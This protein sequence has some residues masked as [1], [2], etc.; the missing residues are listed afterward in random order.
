LPTR[1]SLGIDTD[2]AV[3]F[4]RV[5][6]GAPADETDELYVAGTCKIYATTDI[7]SEII[8]G[9]Y[10][11]TRLEDT[12][13]ALQTYISASGVRETQRSLAFQFQEKTIGEVEV[14]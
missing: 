5:G 7:Y 8:S 13:P 14:N 1:N 11:V 3:Q 6:I 12:N 10:I 2:D 4:L 9:N